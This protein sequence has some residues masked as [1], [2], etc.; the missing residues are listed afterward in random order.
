MSFGP[1]TS[2]GDGKVGFPIF[3][4]LEGGGWARLVSLAE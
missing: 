1:A 3:R 4:G 2:G